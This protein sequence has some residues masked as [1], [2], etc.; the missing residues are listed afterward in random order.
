M[1]EKAMLICEE[2]RAKS[3][4]RILKRNG[5]EKKIAIEPVTIYFDDIKKSSDL[6]DNKNED[7]LQEIQIAI[8]KAKSYGKSGVLCCS[9]FPLLAINAQQANIRTI[10][11][12]LEKSSVY[13]RRQIFC[14]KVR[15][16]CSGDM[17]PH[18]LIEL[19]TDTIACLQPLSKQNYR[20]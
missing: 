6:S 10:A 2:N 15:E 5:I 11:Y 4:Y 13:Q 14:N 1:V 3:I 8:I 20:T 17:M 18:K 9:F 7:N 16:T 19:A 12:T